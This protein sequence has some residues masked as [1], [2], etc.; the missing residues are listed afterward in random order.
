MVIAEEI[1]ATTGWL[2]SGSFGASPPQKV[3]EGVGMYIHLRAS[4]EDDEGLLKLFVDSLSCSRVLCPR[5]GLEKRIDVAQLPP[6]EQLRNE[7][8]WAGE[9]GSNPIRSPAVF[10]RG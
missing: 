5:K 10:S 3:S 8:K 1:L 2:W 9:L 7:W 4:M 6:N